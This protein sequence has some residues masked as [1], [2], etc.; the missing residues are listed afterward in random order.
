MNFRNQKYIGHYSSLLALALS[1][2]ATVYLI[3]INNESI[4]YYF[5]RGASKVFS[6][7]KSLVKYIKFNKKYH[8]CS[9]EYIKSYFLNREVNPYKFVI[10]DLKIQ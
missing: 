2:K 5:I 8:P 9:D 6:S 4:P 7:A 3:K 1:N 10:E